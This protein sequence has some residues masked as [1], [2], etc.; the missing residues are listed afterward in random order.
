MDTSATNPGLITTRAPFI[1]G[2]RSRGEL[3][4]TQP[5]EEYTEENHQSWRNLYARM[6]DRWRRGPWNGW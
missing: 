6:D 1:E 2:A 5:Y 4:I 3:F